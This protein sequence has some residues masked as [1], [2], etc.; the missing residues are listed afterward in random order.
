[1]H[2]VSSSKSTCKLIHFTQKHTEGLYTEKPCH[3]IV[4]CQ[5][6]TYLIYLYTHIQLFQFQYAFESS[7]FN[8]QLF[9]VEISR[10]QRACRVTIQGKWNMFIPKFIYFSGVNF[11]FFST[12]CSSDGHPQQQKITISRDHKCDA[13]FI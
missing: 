13:Y 4:D 1:M 10:R 5:L 9:K 12:K 6:N 2:K 8:V 3:H 7:Q 11:L